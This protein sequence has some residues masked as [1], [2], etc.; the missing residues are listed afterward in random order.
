M[1]A[2]GAKKEEDPRGDVPRDTVLLLATGSE[3]APIAGDPSTA[4]VREDDAGKLTALTASKEAIVKDKPSFWQVKTPV[5]S[6]LIV[7]EIPWDGGE[8]YNPSVAAEDFTRTGYVTGI[9]QAG[10]I[11]WAESFKDLFRTMGHGWLPEITNTNLPVKKIEVRQYMRENL[12]RSEISRNKLHVSYGDVTTEFLSV[13]SLSLGINIHTIPVFQVSAVA[14]PLTYTVTHDAIARWKKTYMD[15]RFSLSG[16]TADCNRIGFVGGRKWRV[17]KEGTITWSD[18]Y[19]NYDAASPVIREQYRGLL[20][21]TGGGVR[22]MGALVKAIGHMKWEANVAGDPASR[23]FDRI[24]QKKCQFSRLIF[25]LWTLYY[26]A[27]LH[28]EETPDKEFVIKGT[29]LEHPIQVIEEGKLLTQIDTL[30]STT[31]IEPFVIGRSLHGRSDAFTII[32]NLVVGLSYTFKAPHHFVLTRFWP[33]IYNVRIFVY[34]DCPIKSEPILARIYPE[35]ILKTINYLGVMLGQ[36]TFFYDIGRTV[37]SFICRP[38]GDKLWMG[39][40]HIKMRLP[41]F[42]CQQTLF[43]DLAQGN[44]GDDYV[45]PLAPNIYKSIWEGNILYM[46]QSVFIRTV[47]MERGFYSYAHTISTSLFDECPRFFRDYKNYG[48]WEADWTYLTG[49]EANGIKLN[50]YAQAVALRMGLGAI[51]NCCTAWIEPVFFEPRVMLTSQSPTWSET[52]L[53]WNVV[54]AET[55]FGAIVNGLGLDEHYSSERI[56]YNVDV[57]SRSGRAST[58]HYASYLRGGG[59]ILQL[60]ANDR[61]VQEVFYSSLPLGPDTLPVDGLFKTLRWAQDASITWAYAFSNRDANLRFFRE[62][63]CWNNLVWERDVIHTR[64]TTEVKVDAIYRDQ[65]A[66]ARALHMVLSSKQLEAWVPGM[67]EVWIRYLARARSRVILHDHL[68]AVS[69]EKARLSMLCPDLRMRVWTHPGSSHD[70]CRT[71][72]HL[73]IFFPGDPS[74]WTNYEGIG[75]GICNDIGEEVLALPTT[76]IVV[77]GQNLIARYVKQERSIPISYFEPDKWLGR[78]KKVSTV[79]DLSDEGAEVP[80]APADDSEFKPGLSLRPDSQRLLKLDISRAGDTAEPMGSRYI[81]LTVEELRERL[82]LSRPRSS[83][84]SS[85]TQASVA[86]ALAEARLVRSDYMRGW[87]FYSFSKAHKALHAEKNVD[88]RNAEAWK[89]SQLAVALDKI[90]ADASSM[91]KGFQTVMHTDLASIF[92]A[93]CWHGWY[94]LMIGWHPNSRCVLIHQLHD[95][96]QSLRAPVSDNATWSN[97]IRG[98]VM[99][100]GY[101]C[102]YMADLQALTTAEWRE[103]Y[104]CDGPPNIGEPQFYEQFTAEGETMTFILSNPEYFPGMFGGGFEEEGGGFADGGGSNETAGEAAQGEEQQDANA[105]EGKPTKCDGDGKCGEFHEYKKHDDEDGDGD[106]ARRDTSSSSGA[107]QHSGSSGSGD[108]ESGKGSQTQSTQYGQQ[109]K[110]NTTT[111]ACVS[112]NGMY[113]ANL[114]AGLKNEVGCQADM[115][116][117]HRKAFKLESKADQN[118]TEASK[119]QPKYHKHPGSGKDK[120]P[121]LVERAIVGENDAKKQFQEIASTLQKIVDTAINTEKSIDPR[122]D[123]VF[124]QLHAISTSLLKMTSMWDAAWGASCAHGCTTNADTPKLDGKNTRQAIQTAPK[125]KQT[126]KAAGKVK[127]PKNTQSTMNVTFQSKTTVAAKPKNV[128]QETC[129][130]VQP[131]GRTV[132]CKET[133]AKNSKISSS[134]TSSR[135]QKSTTPSKEASSIMPPLK[136]DTKPITKICE[137]T[138]K[139]LSSK[140][141]TSVVIC[142]SAENT[143]TAKENT[144]YVLES[145]SVMTDRSAA[146]CCSK[147]TSPGLDTNRP[148]R[149]YLDVALSACQNTHPDRKPHRQYFTPEVSHK[150]E[151]TTRNSGTPTARYVWRPK[152]P[153]GQPSYQPSSTA[154]PSTRS[155]SSTSTG[156]S[157]YKSKTRYYRNYAGYQKQ[158]DVQLLLEAYHLLSQQKH[159][160]GSGFMPYQYGIWPGRCRTYRVGASS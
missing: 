87:D 57:P 24:S 140:Q 128:T 77:G 53:V 148:V 124:R 26:A 79:V 34:N 55:A 54:H 73:G 14:H 160:M 136:K 72:A 118:I 126:G 134:V 94:T 48:M 78:D 62:K 158:I 141:T 92:D 85:E 18:S 112:K 32:S 3:P 81:S 105:K 17:L 103:L 35:G 11:T 44:I 146:T 114:D 106:A 82:G 138:A 130:V 39:H 45:P 2:E 58:G 1:V 16:G 157:Q 100:M 156:G 6:T 38:E 90:H 80:A 40:S 83:M 63:D 111:L 139:S 99:E 46:W 102:N 22:D 95:M 23:I 159:A 84:T 19:N 47:L 145:Q 113:L 10:E 119:H 52:L 97:T 69:I 29:K 116:M 96:I 5:V 144:G 153:S 74:E 155:R 41:P 12:K 31:S 36:T 125:G 123:E 98:C 107:A 122:F 59:P 51:F 152:K 75:Y 67:E 147:T 135:A 61:I 104:G 50:L 108:G 86:L 71:D 4:E 21:D 129:V 42:H 25:R 143:S 120:H 15:M 150:K 142:S 91:G 27:L 43:F 28:Q 68:E 9:V 151:R 127:S 121:T 89:I 60:R 8:E 133:G 7:P 76:S 37:A 109:T 64:E 137:T 154:T 33:P 66:I 56:Y 93:L 149:S 20:V 101:M 131:C 30:L 70:K 110:H 49:E 115:T 65:K 117:L 88:E 132:G 13:H